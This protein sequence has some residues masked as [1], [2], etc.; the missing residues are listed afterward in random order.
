MK[1]YY[2]NEIFDWV[3]AWR[4]WLWDGNKFDTMGFIFLCYKVDKQM[5]HNLHM[6]MDGA[7]LLRE[8]GKFEEQEFKE[9]K[10]WEGGNLQGGIFY[11]SL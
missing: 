6:D 4:Y 11:Y 1:W 5:D 8:G 10:G 9:N 7:A 3:F 2:D